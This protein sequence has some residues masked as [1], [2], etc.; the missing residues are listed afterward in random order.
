[1]KNSQH[2][3]SLLKLQKSYAPLRI[4]DEINLFKAAY[5]TPALKERIAYIYHKE[6][7]IF[8]AVT[9]PSLCQEINYI[10]K[11]LLQSIKDNPQKFPT[12]CKMDSI[13][14]YIPRNFTHN[15]THTS[16]H[17][18]NATK[19]PYNEYAKGDF[20]NHCE[21]DCVLFDTFERIRLL[22]KNHHK[23]TKIP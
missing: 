13:K 5:L 9:H 16:T 20:I 22:I 6:R 10:G 19:I 11:Q 7:T 3:I 2:I 1:M 4:K 18:Q 17:N 8:F 14:A 23:N 12:L 21:Q 15:Q